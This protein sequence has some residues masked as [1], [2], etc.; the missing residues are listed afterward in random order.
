MMTRA[1]PGLFLAPGIFARSHSRWQPDCRTATL[2]GFALECDACGE[3]PFLYH[4]FRD[5]HCPRC[6]R[7]ASQDWCERQRA[8]VLP[9]TYHPLVFTFPDTPNAGVEVHPNGGLRP[10]V[11]DGVGHLERL[12]H[13]SQAVGWAIGDDGHAPK[14]KDKRWCA[15]STCTAWCPAAPWERPATGIRPRVPTSSRCG[16]CRGG[17][18]SRL[19]TDFETGR[20]PRITDPREVKRVFDALLVQ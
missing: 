9:V 20:L 14:L 3:R 15:M 13:R 4:A 7:R 19:R 5:R 1:Q 2:G 12:R 16:R 17:F 18:V 6:Q 8:A 11:R 10:V